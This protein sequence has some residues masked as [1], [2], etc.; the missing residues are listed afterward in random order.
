MLIDRLDPRAL[1]DVKGGCGGL[2]RQHCLYFRNAGW[3]ETWY[4]T[5]AVTSSDTSAKTNLERVIVRLQTAAVAVHM[6][7][8]PYSGGVGVLVDRSMRFLGRGRRIA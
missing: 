6:P 8:R 2:D 3:P 1:T 7:P 5:F 4:S